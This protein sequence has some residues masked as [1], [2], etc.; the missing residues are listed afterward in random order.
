MITLAPP[1]SRAALLAFVTA[2]AKAAARRDDALSPE[3]RGAQGE[4]EH[5]ELRSKQ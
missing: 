2:L 5:D 1:P 4:R 3:A